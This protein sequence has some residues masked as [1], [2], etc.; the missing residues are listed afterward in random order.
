M[1]FVNQNMLMLTLTDVLGYQGLPWN[2][3]LRA[4]FLRFR[5][6]NSCK[7][8][9][10]LKPSN[11]CHS[12][13]SLFFLLS[14]YVGSSPFSWPIQKSFGGTKTSFSR[15]EFIE[16]F[17]KNRCFT[18]SS[19]PPQS[20]AAFFCMITRGPVGTMGPPVPSQRLRFARGTRLIQRCSE[21]T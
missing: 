19:S 15:Y 11:G 13:S 3:A 6:N 2:E 18:H 12:L 8:Q 9:R 7:V 21:R 1:H 17:G 16:T 5:N 20:H 14:Q 10:D 4:E